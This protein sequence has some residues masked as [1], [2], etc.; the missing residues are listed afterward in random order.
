MLEAAEQLVAQH[1]EHPESLPSYQIGEL[2]EDVRLQAVGAHAVADVLGNFSSEILPASS[3]GDSQ[4][5]VCRGEVLGHNAISALNLGAQGFRALP[6]N[7]DATLADRHVDMLAKSSMVRVQ[8]ASNKG[9]AEVRSVSR[10]MEHG[11]DF[12]A[13]GPA[14]ERVRTTKEQQAIDMAKEKKVKALSDKAARSAKALARVTSAEKDMV[15]WVG[16]G[17]RPPKAVMEAWLQTCPDV[18]SNRELDSIARNL[19]E[20]SIGL[21]KFRADVKAFAMRVINARPNGLSFKL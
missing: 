4:M 19:Q 13:F 17:T 16:G 7:I 14:A 8:G 21:G 10:G 11:G 18:V 1:K 12:R 3:S 5:E 15:A 20:A 9:R 2:A 6:K